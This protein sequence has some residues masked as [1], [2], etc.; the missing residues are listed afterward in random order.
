MKNSLKHIVLSVVLFA[1]CAVLFSACSTRRERIRETLSKMEV[2]EVDHRGY[3]RYC[4]DV[5]KPGEFAQR[6]R[7]RRGIVV[8]KP[9]LLSVNPEIYT[10][11]PEIVPY[12]RRVLE[13]AKTGKIYT[14][15]PTE[16]E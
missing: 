4:G 11:Q 7:E 8:G 3:V 9:V 1:V 12:I 2:V 16:L 10:N 15:I 6:V 14:K 13:N 5:M